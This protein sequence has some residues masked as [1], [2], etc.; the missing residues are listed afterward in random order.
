MKTKSFS[1]DVTFGRKC[2]YCVFGEATEEQA[3]K[4]AEI[5]SNAVEEIWP[6]ES[7]EGGER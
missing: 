6:E 1:I 2:K 4:L 5:I 3:D 7:E